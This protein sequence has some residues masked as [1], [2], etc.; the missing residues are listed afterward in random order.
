[1]TVIR[2]NVF[3]RDPPMDLPPYSL[4]TIVQER[5]VRID[6]SHDTQRKC[7]LVREQIRDTGIDEHRKYAVGN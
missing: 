4:V 1:M 5:A 2:S 3:P 6:H 7:E